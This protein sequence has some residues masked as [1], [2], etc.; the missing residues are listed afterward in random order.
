MECD[1]L[2]TYS[3]ILDYIKIIKFFY[4]YAIQFLITHLKKLLSQINISNL[5]KQE[6]TLTT[7]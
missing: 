1:N 3:R 6:Q 4:N 5:T 7:S 2:R